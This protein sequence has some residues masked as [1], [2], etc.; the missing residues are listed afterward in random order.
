[1]S[2]VT[3]AG[4]LAIVFGGVIALAGLALIGAL[5]SGGSV[6]VGGA[7]LF[8]VMT[9]GGGT[10]LIGIG[11]TTIV[12]GIEWMD[13][14]TWARTEL[15]IFAW[16]ALAGAIGWLGYSAYRTRHVHFIH[17]FRGTLFFLVTGVPAIAMIVL[18]HCRA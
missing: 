14:A 16:L 1:M 18:L 9:V 13:G 17:V 11:V 2:I 5:L 4:V 7:G 8:A 10:L 12:A 3:A 6:P 15:E